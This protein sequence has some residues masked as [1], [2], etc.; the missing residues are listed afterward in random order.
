MSGLA[1]RGLKTPLLPVRFLKPPL[2]LGDTGA[3]FRFFGFME[4][5]GNVLFK[6]RRMKSLSLNVEE[7]AVAKP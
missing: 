1:V 5:E 4:V 3:L 7:E 2:L 6:I